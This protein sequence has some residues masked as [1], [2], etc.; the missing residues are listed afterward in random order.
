MLARNKPVVARWYPGSL[1]VS[2]STNLVFG[3]VVF[4]ST[5]AIH[6]REQPR[7]REKC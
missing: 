3:E 1:L 2:Q 5:S 6:H 7:Q 4:G